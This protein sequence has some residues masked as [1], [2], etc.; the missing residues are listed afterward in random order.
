MSHAVYNILGIHENGFIG[1]SFGFD[2][3]IDEKRQL[4]CT[5]LLFY[6]QI[7]TIQTF[8]VQ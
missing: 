8:F 4:D 2:C 1:S 5:S 3:D 7:S 6:N